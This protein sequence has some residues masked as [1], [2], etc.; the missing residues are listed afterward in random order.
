LAVRPLGKDRAREGLMYSHPASFVIGGMA[1][2]A[3]AVLAVLAVTNG[4]A[5]R[6]PDPS[7]DVD[8][9]GSATPLPTT[10]VDGPQNDSRHSIDRLIERLE[11]LREE[12]STDATAPRLDPPTPASETRPAA[13][14]PGSSGNGCETQ[15][16]REGGVTR[17]AVRCEFQTVNEDGSGSVSISSSSSS[18]VSSTSSSSDAP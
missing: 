10:A 15:R 2:L 4:G 3:V 6:E 9:I 13:P 16:T 11:S 8:L 12:M 14:E 7:F 5:A 1:G 17:T 18:S